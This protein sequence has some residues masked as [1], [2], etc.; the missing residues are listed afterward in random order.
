MGSEHLTRR[1]APALLLG[2]IL[3]GVWSYLL[4]T[5]QVDWSLGGNS[6]RQGDWLIHGLAE[7]VRRGPF[8]TALLTVADVLRV[9]PL[10]LL[11]A[12]QGLIVTL[13][14][15]AVGVAVIKLEATDKLLLMLFSPAF[16]LFFWFNDPQGAMRK[17]MLVYL[18][19]VPLII[20]A[21][22]R[23]ASS[24]AMGLAI[25]I[26]G[27]AV[28][29]HEGN[30]FFLPFLWMA[31]WLVLPARLGLAARVVVLSLPGVLALGA[32]IYALAHPLV[33]DTASICTHL[34]QRGLS[35]SVCDG[36]IAYLSTTPE[37][38]RMHPGRLLSTEFRVFLLIYA[39]CLLAFRLL[40]PGAPRTDLGFLVVMGSGL[41]FLPLYLL[42]GDYGRWL[43]FHISALVLVLLVYFLKTRPDWL[44][45]PLGRL[46]FLCVL[47]LYLVIGV[48]HSPGEFIDGFLVNVVR[49][50]VAMLRG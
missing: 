1:G 35:P 39:A 2:L 4:Y 48:S 18:A 9:S 16:F 21:G 36:A 23:Q 28:F 13:I 42:A 31:L 14:F 33:A 24:W 43:N 3:A 44:Y 19:F 38:G 50:V 46:D 15:G 45:R 6:W 26:F 25:L 47:V 30:V 32:G 37:E 10:A 49:S 17:E 20:A 8:G 12:F 27:G 22:W 29:A 41:A 7:P 5:L 34:V 11:I 40:F